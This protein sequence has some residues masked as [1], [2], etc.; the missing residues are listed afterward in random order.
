MAEKSNNGLIWAILGLSILSMLGTG[1]MVFSDDT[2]EVPAPVITDVDKSE[3]AQN[4]AQ[5]VL[6][7][8]PEQAPS[9]ETPSSE[10]SEED[11]A[12]LKDVSDLD[13]ENLAEELA[14]A[15]LETRDFKRALMDLLNDNGANVESWR[16]IESIVVKDTDTDVNGDDAEVEFELRVYFFNDGDDDEDALESA[17]ISTMLMVEDVDDEEDAE[18]ADYDWST[19]FNFVKFYEN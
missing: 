15:E 13:E 5:L 4:A 12:Y 2:V 16:D 19:D 3:I 18:L 1:A 9:N 7:N 10:L 11:K 17:K 14:L 6:N 8:L